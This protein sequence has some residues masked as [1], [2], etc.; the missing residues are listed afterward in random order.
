MKFK[1]LPI[2]FDGKTYKLNSVFGML[3][4]FENSDKN[5]RNVLIPQKLDLALSCCNNPYQL[6]KSNS[7][8]TLNKSEFKHHFLR[9]YLNW[10]IKSN[11]LNFVLGRFLSGFGKPI[12]ANSTEAI[13][14]F[15]NNKQGIIQNDLCLPRSLFAASTS[16]KFKENG[17][18]FIGVSLPSNLM[19]A[20][21]IE[22]EKQPDP[23][24]NMWINFQPVAA[25]L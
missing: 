13:S 7:I 19:H 3:M 23:F 2:Q 6:T 18:I 9:I 22:D 15:R 25:I 17:V 10:L 24:D 20:W 8:S 12:F 16:K 1:S 5:I 4:E 11:N 14:F 21:I